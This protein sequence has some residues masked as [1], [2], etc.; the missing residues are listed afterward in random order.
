MQYNAFRAVLARAVAGT[1]ALLLVATSSRAQS[2]PAV[3]RPVHDDESIRSFRVDIPDEALADLRRRIVATRWPEREPVADGS[4]GVQLATIQEL[5]RYWS[6][7]YDWRKVEARLNALP[8]FLTKIDGLDL[9]FLHVRSRHADALPLIVT[10]GWPGSVIE[11]LKIVDPLTNST[12]HGGSA[13]DAFHAN[14]RGFLSFRPM[15][16]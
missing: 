7:D 3:A 12:A 9:H 8:Q 1:L 6:K 15:S 13:S 2:G 14:T 4:Q 5:A 10:H 16:S 11:Q